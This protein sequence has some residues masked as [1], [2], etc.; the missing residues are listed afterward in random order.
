MLAFL[1]WILKT[2]LNKSE[3]TGNFVKNWREIT[4]K[5]SKLLIS[6]AL[7]IFVF[8]KSVLKLICPALY[9]VNLLI[10]V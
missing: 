5:N 9:T 1:L 3:G 8:K 10:N 2:V 4:L 6:A 7:K